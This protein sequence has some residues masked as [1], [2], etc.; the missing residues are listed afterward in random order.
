MEIVGVNKKD[1]VIC[2]AEVKG[3]SF[4][5]LRLDTRIPNVTVTLRLRDT[6]V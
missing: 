3:K 5:F 1:I 4:S 2:R 6:R